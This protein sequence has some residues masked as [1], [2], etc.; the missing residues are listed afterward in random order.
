MIGTKEGYWFTLQSWPSGQV[1]YEFYK[2][3]E[4]VLRGGASSE[5]LVML[6]FNEF[7]KSKE[8]S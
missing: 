6:L 4:L 2:G 8:K 1:D 7:V 3:D 5:E